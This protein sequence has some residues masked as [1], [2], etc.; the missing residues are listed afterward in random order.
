MAVLLLLV[1]MAILLGALLAPTGWL[2][3]AQIVVILLL[4]LVSVTV[5]PIWGLRIHTNNQAILKRAMVMAVELDDA[6]GDRGSFDVGWEQEVEIVAGQSDIGRLQSL[7]QQMEDRHVLLG[8]WLAYREETESM[9]V[10][11]MIDGA[12][13]TRAFSDLLR[14][15]SEQGLREAEVEF[16]MMSAVT[17]L[18]IYERF[19]ALHPGLPAIP[20]DEIMMDETERQ[21]SLEDLVSLTE[22]SHTLALMTALPFD[23]E[24]SSY[25][26]T[27][28]EFLSGE[29]SR[30]V[31]DPLGDHVRRAITLTSE[32][33]HIQEHSDIDVIEKSEIEDLRLVNLQSLEARL[34]KL[35][36][37]VDLTWNSAD[38]EQ[39][40]PMRFN[41]LV[42]VMWVDNHG[43]E[44]WKF[45]RTA[46]I[47]KMHHAPGGF[48]IDRKSHIWIVSNFDASTF[49]KAAARFIV[50]QRTRPKYDAV[51]VFAPWVPVTVAQFTNIDGVDDAYNADV[52]ADRGAFDGIS[53][54]EFGV[55]VPPFTPPT[56][57]QLY[58]DELGGT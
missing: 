56:A 23:L 52:L 2:S 36:D 39:L 12:F 37:E 21:L 45:I 35:R 24:F 44:D 40:E 8:E 43:S 17:E 48:Y 5:L 57:R 30:N 4:I 6:L 19:R 14:P 55:G 46:D 47:N 15:G 10:S 32:I 25:G 41:E 11:H 34:E 53:R 27:T 38:I 20:V 18:A 22:W 42:R 33:N 9:G 49:S 7:I 51:V 13:T 16:I 54:S 28:V 58:R 31:L 26:D 3:D 50:Y 1:W 29:M